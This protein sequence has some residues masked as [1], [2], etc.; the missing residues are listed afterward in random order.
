[1]SARSKK[2]LF[3]I[4]NEILGEL[5]SSIDASHNNIWATHQLKQ[6][7]KSIEVL[8]E[9][10][11]LT[12]LTVNEITLFLIEKSHLSRV[13]FQTPRTETLY[14]WRKVNEYEMMPFL[15]PKGYY[16]HLSAMYFHG[17]LDYEPDNVFF[18]HEQMA[19]PIV[20]VL[21]QTRIDNAFHKNQ[22]VTTARTKYMG[23]EYWLLNGKQ[24]NNYGTVIMRI[25]S[26]TA[27]QTNE[28]R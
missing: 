19:R 3:S 24:T 14:L 13:D 18:N 8:Q 20:G 22:R 12:R 16:T 28:K 5:E 21:E 10:F 15:R 26:E 9:V 27:S 1:M 23:K 2:Q 11:Q 25:P 4:L 17:L 7:L 6:F